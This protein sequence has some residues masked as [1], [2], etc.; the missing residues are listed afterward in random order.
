MVEAMCEE[1]EAVS[2]CLRVILERNMVIREAVLDLPSPYRE[3]MLA[4]YWDDATENDVAYTLGVTPDC[5]HKRLA[6]GRAMV[7]E[8]LSA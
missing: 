3:T 2:C 7:R 8:A 6:R 5:V 4:F 1:P